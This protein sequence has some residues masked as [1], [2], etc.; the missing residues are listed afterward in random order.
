MR[1]PEGCEGASR[2]PRTDE[3]RLTSLFGGKGEGE[4]LPTIGAVEPSWEKAMDPFEAETEGDMGPGLELRLEVCELEMVE[5]RF[6]SQ[7]GRERRVA[8]GS[9]SFR[10]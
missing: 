3:E 8:V 5:R 2:A 1:E 9:K 7:L 10:S 6:F 4:R